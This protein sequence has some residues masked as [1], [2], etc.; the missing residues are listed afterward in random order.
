MND[1]TAWLTLDEL[2]AAAKTEGL[3]LT[4]EQLHRWRKAGLMP[5]PVV[6]GLGRGVG[7]ESLYPRGCLAQALMIGELLKRTRDLDVVRWRM[8]LDGFPV[9]SR[10]FRAQLDAEVRFLLEQ[11]QEVTLADD[12]D[13][14]EHGERYISGLAKTAHSRAR[15][16]LF[17]YMR[18]HLGRDVMPV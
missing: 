8:F 11:R 17:R 18:E 6:R 13:D 5:T 4:R 15:S 1:P 14:D 9:A 10:Q 2:L 7:R 3:S 16:P 12:P